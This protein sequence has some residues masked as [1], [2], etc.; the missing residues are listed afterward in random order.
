MLFKL[1]P[2]SLFTHMFSYSDVQLYGVHIHYTSIKVSVATQSNVHLASFCVLFHLKKE[3][4]FTFL[5]E[6]GILLPLFLSL[7]CSFVCMFWLPPSL[8]LRLSPSLSLP[9]FLPLCLPPSLPSTTHVLSKAETIRSV[10]S[11]RGVFHYVE[12]KMK[13]ESAHSVLLSELKGV[14][15]QAL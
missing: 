7:D 9:L 6:G 5:L 4:S 12:G 11:K 10:L 2:R 14:Y 1:I 3:Q 15:G 8:H 13:G